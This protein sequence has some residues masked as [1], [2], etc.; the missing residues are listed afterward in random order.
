MRALSYPRRQQY[1]RLLD[2]LK[3]VA[4]AAVAL[5]LALAA[6]GAGMGL[7]A[8]GLAV[9][10]AALAVRSRR[11]LSLARRSRIGAN[12]EQEVR[13]ALR[14]LEREGWR[15]RHSL[16]W[17]HGGDI[18]HIAI[19]PQSAGVAFAI[20]TKTRTYTPGDLA[21]VSEIA[22]WLRM[23]RRRWCRYG[24]VPVLCLAG[25]RGVERWEGG[26]AVVSLDRL[27]SILCRLAGT[28]RKPWFL[29]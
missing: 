10:A 15:T 19:A 2:A 4:V 28:T 8:L 24:A 7:P 26:V 22:V 18:D 21:R 1:R 13:V 12:S 29:L 14:W 5:L 27:L 23:R 20:E 3:A 6:A 9:L 16:R 17:H 11:S 25:T